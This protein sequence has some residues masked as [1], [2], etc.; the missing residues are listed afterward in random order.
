MKEQCVPGTHIE[1]ASFL[2]FICKCRCSSCDGGLIMHRLGEVNC[3]PA[4][5]PL[6]RDHRIHE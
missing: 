5:S 2:K 4:L 6:L 1:Q 3:S